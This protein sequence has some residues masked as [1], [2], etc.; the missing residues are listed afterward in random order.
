LVAI[1]LDPF[2][3]VTVGTTYPAATSA[4]TSQILTDLK[5]ECK[6]KLHFE[7]TVHRPYMSDIGSLLI[8]L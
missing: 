4:V 5:T 8:K 1:F 3:A 7:L 6:Q 2:F